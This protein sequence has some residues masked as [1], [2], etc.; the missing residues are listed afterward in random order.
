MLAFQ[1]SRRGGILK[2]KLLDH[3]VQIGGQ[4]LVIFKGDLLV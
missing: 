3:R 1:A 4:A 2:I